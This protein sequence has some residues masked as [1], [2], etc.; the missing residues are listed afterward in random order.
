MTGV[1]RALWRGTLAVATLGSFLL[2]LYDTRV[3]TD[4]TD[5]PE[6]RF[7][8]AGEHNDVDLHLH[9]GSDGAERTSGPAGGGDTTRD[10]DDGS[11]A[12]DDREGKAGPRS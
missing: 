4:D 7:S 10:S 5:G 2:A 8:V 9:F 6:Q 11:P 12:D 1:V 3:D